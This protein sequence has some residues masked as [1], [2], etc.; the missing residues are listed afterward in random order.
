[1]AAP[2]LDV[3]VVGSANL[4]LVATTPRLPAPGETVLGTAYAEHAGGKGLN[5]A[6][7]AARGGAR[8]A[9]VGALGVDAAADH[10]VAVMDGEGIDHERVVRCPDRPT[11]R[12]LISVGEGGEN[13]IIVIAGANGVVAP[14]AELP[15]C[16]VVALQLE[17]PM[18]AVV[19]AARLGRA[20][21]AT[22]LLN[23]APAP[24]GGLPDELLAH[25]DVIV[26]NEHEIALIGGVEAVLGAG[27]TSVVVTM[28]AAGA[29][30][31]TAGGSQEI[32]PYPVTPVDTTGAGDAFCGNLA[33]RLATG[34]ELA[35]ALAWAAA[36]AALSTTTAGAVPSFPAAARTQRAVA[37]SN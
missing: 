32:A 36:A 27:V 2:E 4:D 24:P 20:A 29:R 31:H 22:I 35:A 11:G 6:V 3:V 19:A 12:A 33:A 18:D 14:P 8:V 30:L 34:D 25:V 7:A 5:Q 21:G 23:P 15:S 37:T 26:P 10:L 17:I 16:R 1:M 28:G 13:S 9:F